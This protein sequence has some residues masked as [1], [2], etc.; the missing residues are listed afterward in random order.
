MDRNMLAFI[1]N[2][3][4]FRKVNFRFG[5]IDEIKF[6]SRGLSQEN[7]LLY[8]YVRD[9]KNRIQDL[10]K[11]LQCTD[12]IVIYSSENKFHSSLLGGDDK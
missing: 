8:I 5:N 2:L 11:I 3:I 12:S 9:L 4:S 10:L 7:V 1:N 6:V